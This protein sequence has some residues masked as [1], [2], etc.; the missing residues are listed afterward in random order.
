MYTAMI[1]VAVAY[2]FVWNP[3][4]G[5]SGLNLFGWLLGFTV[6][7]RLMYTFF[8]VP[9]TAL[10]AEL[11]QDYDERTSLMSVRYFFA[12]VGGLTVQ[13][14]LFFFL[15][16]PS[17]GDPSG[18]FHLPGWHAYGLIGASCI[19]GSIAITSFGVDDF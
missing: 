19:L 11:T 4:T 1:P 2:F 8:E 18:F 14:I 3:P 9:S 5:L 13:I 17:E 12:W 16:V 6:I 10:A 15:L 7:V